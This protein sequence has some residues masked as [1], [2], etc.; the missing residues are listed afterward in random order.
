METGKNNN[1]F[2]DCFGRT[3]VKENNHLVISDNTENFSYSFIDT[4]NNQSAGL[5]SFS[6]QE[7]GFD[8]LE[9]KRKIIRSQPGIQKNYIRTTVLFT[10][11]ECTLIPEEVYR[12][13]D[14]ENYIDLLFSD[15][16]SGQYHA[17]HLPSLGNYL[18]YKIPT[19]TDKLYRGLF[20]GAVF[21]HSTGLL[22]NTLARISFKQN[23]PL[24]HTHFSKN[25]F[26]MTILS[27]GKL[28]FYNSFKF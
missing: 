21:Y 9:E 26:G 18:V 3:D 24:V 22:L 27:K 23:G 2:K 7:S 5:C 8:K 16:F 10:T 19:S 15:V 6:L 1:G 4:K 20:P 13:N 11:R 28:L 25:Y 14:K 12:K 17:M